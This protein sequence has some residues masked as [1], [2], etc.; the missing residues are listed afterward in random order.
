[1][2]RWSVA[3]IVP[4][5]WGCQDYPD[6]Q[7]G[8]DMD[9]QPGTHIKQCEIRLCVCTRTYKVTVSLFLYLVNSYSPFTAPFICPIIHVFTC[10]GYLLPS[11]TLPFLAHVKLPL[12]NSF[13]GRS[14]FSLQ[15]WS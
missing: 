15:E 1:M 7:M 6:I 3:D 12:P 13:V 9:G 11:I 5:L 4:A 10:H 8:T 2:P 14:L